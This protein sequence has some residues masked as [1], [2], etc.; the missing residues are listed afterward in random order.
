LVSPTT[1]A[2]GTATSSPRPVE[3]IAEEH[4]ERQQEDENVVLSHR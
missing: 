3:A 2:W 4:G 1:T